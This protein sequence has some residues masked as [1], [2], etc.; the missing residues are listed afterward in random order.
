MDTAFKWTWGV[1]L[2]L[3][4]ITV[5]QL[6]FY[7]FK[8]IS[9]YM[10]P[11]VMRVGFILIILNFLSS[12]LF[13]FPNFKKYVGFF[14]F[15]SAFVFGIILFYISGVIVY[16]VLGFLGLIG[17]LIIVPGMGWVLS[18]LVIA[19]INSDG[20]GAV[21]LILFIMMIIVTGVTGRKALKQ[22]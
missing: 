4:V 9:T 17:T 8:W 20:W 22:I 16:E 12:I 5:Y 15:Y 18:A 19:F 7:G 14:H 2:F 10:V 21:I 1:V 3:V 13:V 6:F 11:W